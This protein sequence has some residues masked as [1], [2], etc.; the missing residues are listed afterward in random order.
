[1]TFRRRCALPLVLGLL[2]AWGCAEQVDTPEVVETPEV[3][4]D[5]P[6]PATDLYAIELAP[7][8][9]GLPRPGTVRNLTGRPNLY[10]NQ[11]YFLPGGGELVYTAGRADGGTDIHRLDLDSGAS[12]PLML[13]DPE[14]EY[15]PTPLA[16]GSL[17][18]VRVES[19]GSTQRLWRFEIDADE[20]EGDRAELLLPDMEPVGYQAWL[21]ADRV[22]LFILGSPASL[23]LA[24]VG[25]DWSQLVFEGIGSSLRAIPGEEAVSFVEMGD[26]GRSWIRRL[27]GTTGSTTRIVETRDGGV[28]H[29]WTPDGVLIMAAGR[30]FLAHRPG[31]DEGWVSLGE[32]GPEGIEWSRIAVSPGGD[33]M[34][35]VGLDASGGS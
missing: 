34:V 5:A 26:E 15:S 35:V 12:T 29:A 16:D 28:E 7:G 27:D 25:T 32:A 31:V 8:D 4:D 6:P 19:D 14:N 22:A 30:E 18:V 1:M 17:A 3:A 9:D 10:D 13:T 20:V 11:P 24:E 21:D 2:V 33:L 23:H